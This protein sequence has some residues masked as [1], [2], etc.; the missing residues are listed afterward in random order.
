M[1]SSLP[2]QPGRGPKPSKEEPEADRDDPEHDLQNAL[3]RVEALTKVAKQRAE[4][5][6]NNSEARDKSDRADERAPAARAA[7][8]APGGP[9]KKSEI[10]RH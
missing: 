3:V 10:P 7:L 1:Y 5:H 6:K 4:A 8:E 2:V 9:G